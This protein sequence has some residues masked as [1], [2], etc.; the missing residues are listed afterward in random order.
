MAGVRLL[1][2]FSAAVL[3]GTSVLGWHRTALY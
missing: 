1:V 2:S 3:A